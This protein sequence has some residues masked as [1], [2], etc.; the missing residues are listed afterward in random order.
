LPETASPVVEDAPAKIN[1]ALHVTG[2][3]PDGYHF[4]ESLVVFTRLGDQLT[5]ASAQD[6]ALEISGPFGDGLTGDKTIPIL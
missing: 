1:L 5:V 2:K 4:L 6:D 3:R